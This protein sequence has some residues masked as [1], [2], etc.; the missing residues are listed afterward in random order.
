MTNSLLIGEVINKL[1]TDSEDLKD[2]IGNR[3]FPI[4]ASEGAQ[5]PFIVYRRIGL[6]SSGCKDGY[7]EDTV[8]FTITIISET[9]FEGINIAQLVRKTLERQRITTETLTMTD[10]HITGVEEEYQSNA[11]IQTINFITTI[12]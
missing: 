10:C 3:V 2:I 11:Y 5:Y 4:V 8:N 9:Y 6:S 1:L 12:N 7:Y